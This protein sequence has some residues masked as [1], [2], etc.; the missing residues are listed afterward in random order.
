MAENNDLLIDKSLNS[1]LNIR[2]SFNDRY[3]LS[4]ITPAQYG[5]ILSALSVLRKN[6]IWDG[7]SCAFAQDIFKHY[8]NNGSK[9]KILDESQPRL[10][11][12][13][14]IGRK[15]IREFIIKRDKK[16]LRCGREDKLTIDHIE[17]ISKGGENKLGNLQTLCKSCNSIKRDSFKDYRNMIGK[18][19]YIQK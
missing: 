3:G 7:Y 10:I 19:V 11:A 13:K 5:N 4:F 14:F 9:I 6:K 1:I 17:P 15:K 16:C 2:Y 8:Y 12:Q 18:Q